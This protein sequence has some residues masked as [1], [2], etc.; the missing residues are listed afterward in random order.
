MG[1]KT[2]KPPIRAATATTSKQGRQLCDKYTLLVG[3]ERETF[4]SLLAFDSTSLPL[5]QT[6]VNGTLTLYLYENLFPN[7]EKAVAVH[8]IISPWKE[9]RVRLQDLII[10]P[11]P[12]CLSVI[13]GINKFID[14][15]ITPL[16]QEWHSGTAANLG[17]L[18]K[19]D[20]NSYNKN[21][22]IIGFCSRN[23][24]NSLCWPALHISF[25]DYI[26]AQNCNPTLEFD[27]RVSTGNIVQTAGILNVLQYMYTYFVINIGK[28]SALIALQVS[29]DGINWITEG[30]LNSIRPG[31]TKPLIPNSIAKYAR[32]VFL[33][34]E[35]DQS[36][37]L[38][39][40][41]RGYLA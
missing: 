23:C 13:Q 14:F 29:P 12:V 4:Q 28:S 10:D 25:I 21:F 2:V 38:A 5:M 20:E 18:L 9:N 41:V 39:I 35:P 24:C 7:R 31:E 36:T 19:P 32:L 16:V 6:I 3:Q 1:V 30:E 11:V 26:S 8:R 27:C 37:I 15:D 22:G 33:S 34:D 40:C 17:I